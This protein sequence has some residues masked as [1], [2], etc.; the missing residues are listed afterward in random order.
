LLGNENFIDENIVERVENG[1][2]ATLA[3]SDYVLIETPMYQELPQEVVAK[4][5]NSVRE[6]GYKIVIAH[7]ERYTYIQSNPKKI[8]EYFGEDIIFQGNY[9]SILGAYGRT[10]QK[11]IKKLLKDKVINYFASDIHHTNRCFYDEFELIQK[12]LLKVAG[13]EYFEILTEINPKLIIENKEVI[14]YGEK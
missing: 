9:A 14:K 2:N 3:G 7:P 6:K 11:T 10:A 4:M 13:K 12:K 8:V 5:L 1:I